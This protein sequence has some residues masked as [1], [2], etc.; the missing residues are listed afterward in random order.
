MLK[1]I[2]IRAIAGLSLRRFHKRRG[3]PW[4][5]EWLLVSQERLCCMKLMSFTSFYRKRLQVRGPEHGPRNAYC[6]CSM[7][8]IK[9]DSPAA[10]LQFGF[11]IWCSNI[12]SCCNETAT[13]AVTGFR[14]WRRMR[15]CQRGSSPARDDV[16]CLGYWWHFCLFFLR[17]FL[18]SSFQIEGKK[19]RIKR[20]ILSS[21][22]F[23]SLQICKN[24][25]TYLLHHVISSLCPRGTTRGQLNWF[26]ILTLGTF[27][28]SFRRTV[29]LF[30]ILQL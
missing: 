15:R 13:M 9:L 16:C 28:K 8:F 7:S 18:P 12:W 26:E 23:R 21:I 5:A 30:N 6:K 24:S 4:L 17:F 27:T 29:I 1:C 14:H 10:V 25:P 3:I 11:L 22:L 2:L 20:S 19:E